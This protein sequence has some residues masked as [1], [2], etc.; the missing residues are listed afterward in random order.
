MPDFGVDQAQLR[1]RDAFYSGKWDLVDN[2]LLAYGAAVRADE[3]YRALE[4][5]IAA[6]QDCGRSDGTCSASDCV[7]AVRR[8]Q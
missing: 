7:A 5:A 6:L 4:D 1:V 3:R 2:A 8:L